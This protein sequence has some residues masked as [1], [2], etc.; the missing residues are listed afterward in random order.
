MAFLDLGLL[1]VA[2]ALVWSASGANRSLQASIGFAIFGYVSTNYLIP[3]LAPSFTKIG[4]FGKDLS[5]PNKPIIPETVGAVAATSYLFV[6]FFF[7]PFLFY[8]YLVTSTTGGGNREGGTNLGD[9]NTELF[10]HDK[11]AGYLSAILCLESTV[12]LGVADDLFDIRWRHKFFLPAIAAI[13]LLI[14][15]YVDFGITHVL[16]PTQFLQ[17]YFQTTLIELG[18]FYYVY[19]AAVAIFCPNSIN[20]LAGVNGL[21][22]GQS[23]VLAIILLINDGCYLISGQ[24]PARES[25]LFSACLLFPF[26]GVSLALLKYNW[27]P[28]QVFVGDTYCYF[29]GMVFAVVGILGHFSKTLLLFFIP[30][31]FNFMYSVPQLFGIIPCP[32]HRMPRFN[33]EDGFM[34]PSHAKFEKPLPT[35]IEKVL[36]L[37][38][39]LKLLKIVEGEIEVEK[40]GKTI[41]KKAIT[42]SNNFTLINLVLVWFGPLREDKLCLTL[43]IIQF[44]IGMLAIVGRHT[45]GPWLFGYDNLWVVQ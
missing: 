32:R 4:L 34:Y 6:M 8:K 41:K 17:D 7:I 31:I 22:V 19:M 18:G 9:D 37:L 36:Y 40:N 2:I 14:V 28:S 45:I 10:P 38:N 12:L 42:E 21:E 25:H 5:K 33:L 13:P 16:V 26:L 44:S 29:A 43:L 20:I 3:R 30:Q 39:N 24:V 35:V 27:W 11:L 15:Y 23:V 1:V